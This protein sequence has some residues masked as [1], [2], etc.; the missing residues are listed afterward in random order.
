[1]RYNYLTGCGFLGCCV[2]PGKYLY[3]G[4]EEDLPLGYHNDDVNCDGDEN[5]DIVGINEPGVG[6]AWDGT[7]DNSNMPLPDNL[8]Y[9][10]I[11]SDIILND[12][13]GVV[14]LD[15]QW[16]YDGTTPVPSDGTPFRLTDTLLT[17]VNHLS[18]DDDLDAV[19]RAL[20]EGDYP[21]FAW[22][23]NL[24]HSSPYAGMT[25]VRSANV[26][27]GP[28]TIDPDWFRFNIPSG[29]TD[30]ICI[31]LTPNVLLSGKIEYFMNPG[32]YDNMSAAGDQTIVFTAGSPKVIITLMSGQY[33]AGGDNYFRIIHDNVGYADW[34]V[35]YKIQP[36]SKV[37][38]PVT[39]LSLRADQKGK[40][41]RVKWATASE[42]NNEKFIVQ[43]SFNNRDWTDIG[44][45]KGS[46][47]TTEETSYWF[48]DKD[49]NAGKNFYRLNQIDFDGANEHTFTVQCNFS[50]GDPTSVVF[51][52]NPVQDQLHFQVRNLKE[53]FD[54]E[55]FNALGQ[56]AYQKSYPNSDEEVS[57]YT[58][59]FS[60]LAAGQ[61]LIRVASGNHVIVTSQLVK[62]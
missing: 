50:L 38:V 24:N 18:V 62:R 19:I 39:L 20:D 54:I 57:V 5:D 14:A 27:D 10:Y 15:R 16:I 1:L 55:V 43:R 30:D 31:E 6:N 45:V 12:G 29:T 34:K 32:A 36:I 23:I 17:D 41:V 21:E 4:S 3:G 51:F 58:I 33:N 26:P 60:D 53:S 11:T 28:N 61:Y 8:R 22:D 47:T 13:D 46:G 37:P 9:T 7:E 44:E 35:P 59:P 42:I 40:D 48:D 49:P 52:P 56:I 2:C 25:H